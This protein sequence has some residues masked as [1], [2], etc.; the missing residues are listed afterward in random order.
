MKKEREKEREREG[1][2]GRRTCDDDDKVT[3]SDNHAVEHSMN[4]N[5]MEE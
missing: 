1:M 5:A 4:T 3:I 2:R